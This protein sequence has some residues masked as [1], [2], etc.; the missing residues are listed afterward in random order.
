MPGIKKLGKEKLNDIMNV[1]DAWGDKKSARF[2][3]Y[4]KL[5]NSG[6]DDREVYRNKVVELCLAENRSSAELIKLGG[7]VFATEYVSA[8]DRQKMELLMSIMMG[9]DAAR[10][11]E[12]KLYKFTPSENRLKYEAE[13]AQLNI[14]NY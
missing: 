3:T 8:S 9:Y 13:L 10:V 4:V 12:D 11:G 1:F 2:I 14:F 5:L 7:M 6:I